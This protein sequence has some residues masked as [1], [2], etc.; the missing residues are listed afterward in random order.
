METKLGSGECFDG[1]LRHRVLATLYYYPQSRH[2]MRAKAWGM[3]RQ[4]HLSL[5]QIEPKLSG[6]KALCTGRRALMLDW[7]GLWISRTTGTCS[8]MGPGSVAIAHPGVCSCPGRGATV[9][10]TYHH[11]CRLLLLTSPRAK[12]SQRCPS[13]LVRLQSDSF[14][15]AGLR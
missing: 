9:P 8:A 5:C 1:W 11:S 14:H 12:E 4:R 3:G 13:T 2:S 6:I 15:H 7:P 10:L